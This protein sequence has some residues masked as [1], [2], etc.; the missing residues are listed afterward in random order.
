[1]NIFMCADVTNNN[2]EEATKFEEELKFLEAWLETSCL[3]EVNTE[4]VV[5]MNVEDNISNVHMLDIRNSE[6][7]NSPIKVVPS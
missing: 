2:K 5:S 4:V 7:K 6:R 1:M 3:S